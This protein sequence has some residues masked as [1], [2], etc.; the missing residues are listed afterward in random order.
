MPLDGVEFHNQFRSVGLTEALTRLGI[1]SVDPDILNAHK[2]EQVALHPANFASRHQTIILMMFSLIPAT[3]LVTAI[4]LVIAVGGPSAV[5]GIL[6]LL[7]VLIG[8]VVASEHVVIRREAVWT[9]KVFGLY[10][11][12][13][14]WRVPHQIITLLRRLRTE[15][16]ANSAIRL[17]Y[18]ELSQGAAVLDP[19]LIIIDR[20]T[21]A[22]CILGIWNDDTILHIA[23]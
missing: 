10:S 21:G 7:G 6:V 9:E 1:R 11:H 19:Y 2:A 22:R 14:T 3:C 16:G 8:I 17:I 4:Y 23:S 18:G 20:K 15:V 13:L 12:E 5:F